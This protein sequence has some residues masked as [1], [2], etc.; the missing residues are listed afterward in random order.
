MSAHA[1]APQPMT[2]HPSGRTHRLYWDA[3]QD[4]G[5]GFTNTVSL[6]AL[7]RDITLMGDYSAAC[8]SFDAS[9]QPPKATYAPLIFWLFWGLL[10][11]LA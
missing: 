7:A 10:L 5:T 9:C 11:P 2:A 6:R 1:A 3:F 4:L 8:D